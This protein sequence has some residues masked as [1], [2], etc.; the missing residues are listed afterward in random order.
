[1]KHERRTLLAAA[2]FRAMETG[3]PTY[4]AALTYQFARWA[5]RQGEHLQPYASIHAPE[6]LLHLSLLGQ[7]AAAFEVAQMNADCRA[8][9]ALDAGFVETNPY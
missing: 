9:Q 1:M 5:Q 6:D 7:I 4:H 8:L 3:D 2:Y